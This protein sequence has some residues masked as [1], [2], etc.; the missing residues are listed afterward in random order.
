MTQGQEMQIGSNVNNPMVFIPEGKYLLTA[1]ELKRSS[2]GSAIRSY[3]P[4]IKTNK[5]LLLFKN[6]NKS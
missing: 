3:P 2:F 5:E 6:M 4:Q 1:Y